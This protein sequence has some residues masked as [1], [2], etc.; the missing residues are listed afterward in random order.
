MSEL[1]NVIRDPSSGRVADAA[2]LSAVGDRSPLDGLDRRSLT[3]LD[4]FAQSAAAVGPAGVAVAIPAILASTAGSS[5]LWALVLA[6]ALTVLV[7][8]AVNQYTRRMGSS[9]SLYTFTVKSL[10]PNVG[11]LSGAALAL[12]YSAVILFSLIGSTLVI[13]RWLGI[14]DTAVSRWATTGVFVLLAAAVAALAVRTV[15]RSTRTALVIE[16]IAIVIIVAVTIWFLVVIDAPSVFEV[17]SLPTGADAPA[18]ITAVALAMTGFVGFESA[19][20]LAPETRRPRINV[21]RAIRW[22]VPVALGVFVL[23]MYA[24]TAGVRAVG[25][26]MGMPHGPGTALPGTF[27]APIAAYVLDLAVVGSMFTAA[28]AHTTALARLIMTAGREGVLPRRLGRLHPTLRTPATAVVVIWLG[29]VPPAT[30]LLLQADPWSVALK[31]LVCA[32]LGFLVAYVLV[33]AGV[34]PFLHRIGEWTWPA[35]VGAGTAT[36]ALLGIIGVYAGHIAPESWPVLVG[37]GA[38]LAAAS[39]AMIWRRVRGGLRIGLY[40]QVVGSDLL[41][42]PQRAS[43]R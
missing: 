28:L 30:V 21:P 12:G 18:F 39:G 15:R 27:G 31:V 20:S 35:V 10:G 6:G 29:L 17:T 40:D 16:A 9:G 19:A 43:R 24:E 36:V 7:S 37:A 41:T 26:G 8:W 34:A 3:P 42:A 32:V 33:C 23:S 38:F 25:H 2:S 1:V 11:A 22:T 5:A 4:V 14:G 13:I